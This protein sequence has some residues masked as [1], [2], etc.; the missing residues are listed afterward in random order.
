MHPEQTA[1][2]RDTNIEALSAGTFD[3]AVI[4]GGINGAVSAA[5][6]AARG[7]SVA[8]VERNDFASFTSQESSNMVLGRVQI[9][10]ELR[11]RL[12]VE[13]MQVPQ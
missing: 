9:P 12:G 6:L 1:T 5:A 10:S 2:L 13:A 8:L 7:L 3:V 4:G 11:T